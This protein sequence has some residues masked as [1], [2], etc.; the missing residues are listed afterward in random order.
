V[1]ELAKGPYVVTNVTPVPG[2]ELEGEL[3]EVAKRASIRGSRALELARRIRASDVD[4][5]LEDMASIARDH[6]T[7]SARS[8]YAITA[9]PT[10]SC[11]PR[12]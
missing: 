3:A 6:R 9:I 2:V 4:T 11:P 5:A 12:P 7:A 8:R 10:R 1:R